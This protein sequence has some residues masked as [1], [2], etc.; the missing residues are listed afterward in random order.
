VSISANAEGQGG[1]LY[2]MTALLAPAML[3]L[4]SALVC[5]YAL[6]A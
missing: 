2:V 6:L 3:V 1:A 4:T 5:T